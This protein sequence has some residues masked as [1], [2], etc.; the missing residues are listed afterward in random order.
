MFIHHLH[1][2]H[3]LTVLIPYLLSSILERRPRVVPLALERRA[4]LLRPSQRL[5][6]LS[7]PLLAHLSIFIFKFLSHR[8][9]R[10]HRARLHTSSRLL[11]AR[12]RLRQP[13]PLRLRLSSVRALSLVHVRVQ[14]LERAFTLVQDVIVRPRLSNDRVPRLRASPR[15][16]HLA[17]SMMHLVFIRARDVDVRVETRARRDVGDGARRRDRG[18]GHGGRDASAR[19]ATR[20]AG[21]L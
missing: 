6:H 17:P 8:R 11:L 10:L 13:S 16:H 9:Q 5:S 3:V 1:R 12:L 4:R 14:R 2:R 21:R 18:R 15:A 19:E 7:S 20:D